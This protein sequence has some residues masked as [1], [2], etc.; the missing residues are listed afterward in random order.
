MVSHDSLLHSGVQSR[1]AEAFPSIDTLIRPGL[2]LAY[3]LPAASY[4]ADEDFR[5]L[6]RAL[7][8]RR[9]GIKQAATPMAAL[10][11]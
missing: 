11:T 1:V 2:R 7:A 10:G 9:G 6:L 3:P 5:L 8:Q 4:A